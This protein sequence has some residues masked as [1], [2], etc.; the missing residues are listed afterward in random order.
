MTRSGSAELQRLA[1]AAVKAEGFRPFGRRSGIPMGVS[2]SVLDGRDPAFSNAIRL[3]QTCGVDLPEEAQQ[4]RT[5]AQNSGFA[6]VPLHAAELSAG[7]AAAADAD[8]VETLLAFRRDWLA[9]MGL[10]PARTDPRRPMKGPEGNI[11][12]LR[13]KGEL[14]VKRVE[15][16]PDPPKTPDDT[17]L[18]LVS[19][20]WS[21]PPRG[22][23]EGRSKTPLPRCRDPS[24]GGATRPKH[25]ITSQSHAPHQRCCAA[26]GQ[27]YDRS[28][29]STL[30]ATTG[31][32]GTGG[33]GTG[34][35]AA[36][37]AAVGTPAAAGVADRAARSRK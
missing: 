11:F 8:R 10:P 29:P 17:A 24:A 34:G 28:G 31:G 6:L 27:L 13:H 9:R 16:P 14:V 30:Q 36:G 1:A 12:A 33:E 32:E 37:G 3:L 7:R 5:Q 21:H 26:A 18:V 4:E 35:A 15:L 25:N 20:N 22:W 23:P 19:W 2:R